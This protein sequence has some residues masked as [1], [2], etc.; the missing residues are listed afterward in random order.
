MLVLDIPLTA[1]FLVITTDGPVD[2][3]AVVPT[4]GNT[5]MYLRNR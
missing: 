3:M 4:D 5:S 2:M 1:S